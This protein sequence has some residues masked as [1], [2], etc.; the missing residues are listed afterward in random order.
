MADR[1]GIAPEIG[2]HLSVV[3]GLSDSANEER[4]KARL[5]IIYDNEDIL[6]VMQ[7]HFLTKSAMLGKRKYGFL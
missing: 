5:P 4:H 1:R 3:A 6:T 2:R 7:Y